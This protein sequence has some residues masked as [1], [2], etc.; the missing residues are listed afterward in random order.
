M[1][2]V[3]NKLLRLIPVFFLVTFGSFIILDLMPGDL[4]DALLTDGDSAQITAGMREALEKELNL[5]R[6]TI[7]RYAY[8]LRDI[9][10]GEWGRSYVTGQK[11]ADALVL[12]IPVSL[13]LMLMVQI[14]ALSIAVPLALY[15]AFNAGS[16]IDRMI[17]STAFAVMSVPQFVIAS[18]LVFFFA[19][20]LGWL[21]SSG[22]VPFSEEPLE[23]LRRFILPTIT[24]A[25]A[26]IP[27]LMR[28]LRSD[29]ISTLQEDFIAL[30]KAK[31]LSTRY[32]LFHH[33]LRP[34]SF[35]LIT[36]LGIQLGNLITGSIIIETIFGLP[37]VGKLLIESVEQRD[38]IM[39][40][41]IVTFFALI[42]IAVNLT[43]D[44]L[45]AVLDPRVAQGG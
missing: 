2:Y 25:L 15:S 23:N 11:V 42:Y 36:V 32:I 8:W 34:S 4:V 19:V 20:N 28:V 7:V 27:I 24:I 13:Q 26:E 18:T 6:P 3:Q 41:G 14:L 12:R 33:A 21:P 39:V 31:G 10:T 5:D 44:L 40:Q 43:V 45:Y 38:E 29:M 22:H 35:T 9:A 30:A 37:G 1:H 17:S 16:R